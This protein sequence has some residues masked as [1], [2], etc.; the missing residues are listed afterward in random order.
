MED[1]LVKLGLVGE[2]HPGYLAE[3]DLRDAVYAFE[4]DLEQIAK[5]LVVGGFKEPA[6]TPAMTR[7]LTVD[8]KDS[9]DHAAVQG[10]IEMSGGASLVDVE[11]VSIYPLEEGTRS[12]S[13][14]LTF[15]DREKTLTTDEVDKIM[16]KIRDNL[17][18]K[19]G[20]KFRA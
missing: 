2:V 14:R 3:K 6:S 19:M 5:S 12:L 15:Q 4:L 17:V 11:L 1:R 10:S 18:S 13:Y 8:M 7:D 20:G 16:G 9:T